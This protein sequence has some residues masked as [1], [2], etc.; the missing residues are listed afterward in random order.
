MGEVRIGDV[1]KHDGLEIVLATDG[2]M[3][4]VLH[5]EDMTH[6]WMRSDLVAKHEIV[7]NA[8]KLL[9]RRYERHRLD[10][11]SAIHSRGSD[12]A[13]REMELASRWWTVA[14]LIGALRSSAPVAS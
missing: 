10:A 6:T 3:T 4:L 13:L 2:P 11:Q 1:R 7:D 8:E 12:A 5:P 9:Y 14:C